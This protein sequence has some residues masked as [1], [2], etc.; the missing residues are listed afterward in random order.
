[1]LLCFGRKNRRA[2]LTFRNAPYQLAPQSL[3]GGMITYWGSIVALLA[4]AAVSLG[5][6]F[7]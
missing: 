6:A 3:P 1:M 2:R 4:S 5:S 7:G